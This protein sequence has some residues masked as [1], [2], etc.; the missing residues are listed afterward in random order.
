M[1]SAAIPTAG[2]PTSIVVGSTPSI[3]AAH[4]AVRDAQRLIHGPL[5]DGLVGVHEVAVAHR[6]LTQRLPAVELVVVVELVE[7]RRLPGGAVDALQAALLDHP[8]QA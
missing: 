5:V 2:A 8:E 1:S 3:L 6:H 4:L 7:G